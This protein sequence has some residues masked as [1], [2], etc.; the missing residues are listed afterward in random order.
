[1][2][3]DDYTTWHAEYVRKNT[4]PVTE[5]TESRFWDML[6]VLPPCQWTGPGQTESFFVSERLWDNVVSWFARV[7]GR[8]Y[9]MTDT[10]DKRHPQIIARVR[11]YIAKGAA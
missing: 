7:D 5:V 10:D 3:D 8:F 9:E 2:A 11:E 6:E 4:K 1:M